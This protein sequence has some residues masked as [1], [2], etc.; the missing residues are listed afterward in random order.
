MASIA[1]FTSEFVQAISDQWLQNKFGA[2][3]A[4]PAAGLIGLFLRKL[5]RSHDAADRESAAN[6]WFAQERKKEED[7]YLARTRAER[8]EEG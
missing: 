6:D 5:V 3:I 1:Q 4:V 8:Q 2:L 7:E